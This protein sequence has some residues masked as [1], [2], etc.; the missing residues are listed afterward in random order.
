MVLMLTT[1]EQD[2]LECIGDDWVPLKYFNE[3]QP[4]AFKI[5]DGERQKV[6]WYVTKKE[7]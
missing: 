5:K 7:S 6:M 4:K 3:F 1:R 2:C